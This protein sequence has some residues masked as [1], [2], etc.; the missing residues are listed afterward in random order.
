MKY[1]APFG[2]LV[3]VALNLLLCSGALAAV[4]GRI[5][6]L[7]GRVEIL[8]KGELPATPAKLNDGV[9]P[10]DVL[11]TKSLSKA[12]IT[13]VDNSIVT[14]APGSR[15]AIE[16][17]QV[18]SA[19]GKRQAVLQLFHGLALAVVSKIYQS[20]KPDF[21]VKT[22]TAIMGIRGTEVGI[23]LNPNS[24]T[25]LNFVGRTQVSSIFPEIPG[26]VEL[27]DM[28]GT[29]V[30][31]G[32]PPTLTFV[33]SAEDQKQ[34]MRDL[35]TGLTSRAR[36]KDSGS[37][38]SSS[39]GNQ[40]GQGSPGDLTSISISPLVIPTE[41]QPPSTS[42]SLPPTVELPPS[43]PPA[44]E[45]PPVLPPPGPTVSGP[46]YGPPSSPLA[47]PPGQ[48]FQPPGPPSGPPSGGPPYGNAYG[49]NK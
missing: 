18:D 5:T 19:K 47:G 24:S 10:G 12:Q 34:F 25:F 3:L 26:T 40:P 31:R 15:I 33:V 37:D 36:G 13:F 14:I 49:R 1:K 11:R 41:L 9:E 16:E 23:R 30:V 6:Q 20:E 45:P 8:K 4:V 17:Y 29:N 28:H 44:V 7:E 48:S 43:T 32:Y 46:P 27:I 2:I 35:V 21:V 42:T 22:H 38:S 39:E